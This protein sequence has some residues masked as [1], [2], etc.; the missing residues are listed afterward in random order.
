MP[1]A[2]NRA[3][4]KRP[5]SFGSSRTSSNSLR[6]T[7]QT[8]EISVLQALAID[9]RGRAEEA[10][11][12]VKEAVALARP[13]GWVRP[14]VEAGPAMVEH[15]ASV[16]IRRVEEEIFV[17]QILDALERPVVAPTSRSPL[18]RTPPREPAPLSR[19]DRQ[20]VDSLTNREIDVLEL[21]AQR[22][23]NKE[24]ASSALHLAAHRQRPHP[25]Y[26]RQARRERPPPGGEAS[27]RTGRYR[28]RLRPKLSGT[29]PLSGQT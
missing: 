19:L 6:L 24:I 14:F 9:K 25:A 1:S 17:R 23:Q 13:G 28:P 5:S 18:R 7:G 21:L 27:R 20:A 12:A 26:L 10:L 11:H 29:S 3:S 8:I 4:A 16:W 22:L 2:P 15:S